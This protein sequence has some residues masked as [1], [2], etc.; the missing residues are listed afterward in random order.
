MADTIV[1]LRDGVIQDHGTHAELMRR[2]GL[3][4]E[5]DAL[6]AAVFA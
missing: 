5:V 2:G 3:Y 1:V 6:H 4:A